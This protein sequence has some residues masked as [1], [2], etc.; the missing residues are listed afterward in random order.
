MND[1]LI[2]AFSADVEYNAAKRTLDGLF[3]PFGEIARVADQLP[4]GRFDV[5]DEGFRPGVFERQMRDPGRV[6]QIEFHHGHKTDGLGFLGH[7]RGLSEQS[8][9]LYGTFGVIRDRAAAVEDLLEDGIDGLSIEFRL[10]SDG[11]V[12]DDAGVRWRTSGVLD[13]VALVPVGAYAGARVMAYRSGL[14]DDDIA[15]LTG[16]DP[17]D[18]A[19]AA[20]AV[21]AAEQV[22]A[23]E[24]A[25]AA[26]AKR[27]K[28]DELDEW[29]AVEQA[30]QDAYRARFAPSNV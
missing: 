10:R 11:E 18:A 16:V 27:A 1:V 25:A 3:V 2:R 19:A 28:L 20:A 23:E 22:A 12:I 24:A 29:F 21:L 30:K 8:D 17:A 13:R 7:T 15:E 26:V 9:G 14:S 5:Y 4:S 6:K